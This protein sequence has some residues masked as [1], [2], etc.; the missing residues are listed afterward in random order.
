ML[1][2]QET[3]WG[4]PLA[5]MTTTA[6]PTCFLTR[7]SRYALLHQS[8]RR[9]VRGRDLLQGWP[10]RAAPTSAAFADLDNDGD[11]DL[12]VC[13]YARWVSPDD[14]LAFVRMRKGSITTAR[15]GEV[16]ASAVDH[17]FFGND[18]GR[19]TDVTRVVASHRRGRP[20][21]GVVAAD[22]D[23]DGL[24]DLSRRQ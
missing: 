5:T 18:R 4:S 9:D 2:T 16:F 17:V 13:H 3:A 12:Y 8:R 14:P 10:D 11:L 7:L 19:F 23:G 15:S 6:I 1:W 20:G 24:I 22:F 21:L